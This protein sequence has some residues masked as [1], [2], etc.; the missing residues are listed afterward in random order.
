MDALNIS[1]LI[2]SFRQQTAQAKQDALQNQQH[3]LEVALRADGG[4]IMLRQIENA[5]RGVPNFPTQEGQL[6]ESVGQTGDDESKDHADSNGQPAFT[7]SQASKIERGPVPNI[8]A[9]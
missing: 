4:L 3:W 1:S 7:E 5:L 6:D 2:E 9:V 8:Q